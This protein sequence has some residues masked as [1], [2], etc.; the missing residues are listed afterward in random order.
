MS[1]RYDIC[2]VS[3]KNDAEIAR[4]L[5]DSIRRY[6]LPRTVKIQGEELDYRRILLD[7]GDT[8]MDDAVR[9]QLD[10]SRFLALICSPDTR[11]NR[12][13]LDRLEYF[14]NTH[15]QEEVIAIIVRGEPIDSFPESFI[16]KKVVRHIMPDMSVIE[17]IDTIEPVAAD[18]RA[19]TR[20]RQ[21]EVLRYETVRI[22]A[23]V[24]GLHPDD[25]EQRHR[26][27]RK[28]AIMAALSVV[29]AVCLAAAAIFLR[30]GYIAKTEGD[31]AEK[32]TDLSVQIARRTME[33]LP[34]M[35]EGEPDALGYID[36]AIENARG[37][38][39][40]IGLADLLDAA[41]TERGS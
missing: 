10:G 25:L 9:A 28:K 34:E 35:F 39:D 38:L 4:T 20:R 22:T 8:P 36:E 18:L 6:K 21:R 32:Q 41:E 16:E 29:G 33:E 3:P 7:C 15:G 40:E 17:R 5:A 37:S 27:R 11:Q 12:N 31:I 23:S 26:A 14:R 19:Q 1:E 13:I 2:I 30:L 24:L